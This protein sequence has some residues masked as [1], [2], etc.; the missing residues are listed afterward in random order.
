M[1]KPA[2]YIF[3][4]IVT[5]L[6]TGSYLY[7]KNCCNNYEQKTL[8]KPLNFKT[9]KQVLDSNFQIIGY[10]FEYACETNFNFKKEDYSLVEPTGKS[11]DYGIDRLKVF[12]DKNPNKRLILTGYALNSEKNTSAYPNLGFARA[13]KVKNYF[14]KKGI[15]SNRIEIVGKTINKLKTKEN[16]ILGPIQYEI[17]DNQIS[18]RAQDWETKKETYNEN[19][20]YLYFNSNQSEIILTNEERQRIADLTIYLDNNPNAKLECIGHTDTSGDHYMNIQLAQERATFAKNFLVKNGISEN[21]ISALSKGS[22]EPIADNLTP[23]GKAKNRRTT[24]ILK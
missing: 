20:L 3:L 9:S 1:S 18:A 2:F 15:S 13:N 23:E 24:I 14:I 8:H 4:G 16:K 6:A 10:G 21:R 7:T 22:E 11:I 5:T 17:S 12:F 19:P